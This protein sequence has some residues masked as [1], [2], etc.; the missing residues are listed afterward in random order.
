MW[1]YFNKQPKTR[2]VPKLGAWIE[3]SKNYLFTFYYTQNW[4]S[5]KT[6]EVIED[7][8]KLFYYT[9]NWKSAKTPRSTCQ[10]V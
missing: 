9:Q 3:I 6:D 8:L 7:G 4:K 2:K 10:V 5:A 1:G